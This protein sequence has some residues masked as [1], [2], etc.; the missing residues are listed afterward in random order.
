MLPEVKIGIISDIHYSDGA[1][2]EAFSVGGSPEEY[3]RFSTAGT[4]WAEAVST[5]N[6]ESVDIVFQL[7]DSVD[8]GCTAAQ[9]RTQIQAMVTESG[10]LTMDFAGVTGNH[11]DGAWSDAGGDV[12][13]VANYYTDIDVNHVTR[14]NVYTDGDGWKSY[15]Y[16]LNGIRFLCVLSNPAGMPSGHSDW[17]SARI[18]ETTMPIIVVTHVPVW[19]PSHAVYSS[20]WTFDA[21]YAT[22]EPIL[23][24][25]NVQ[26]VFA[27]HYHW[28]HYD[29]K[30]EDVPCFNFGGSVLCPSAGDNT[31]YIVKIKADAF[32]KGDQNR[33]AI[34]VVGYGNRGTSK[35]SYPIFNIK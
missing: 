26:A 20:G 5:F 7:G 1:D 21:N 27:G 10:N 28:G 34:E 6:S 12:P 13:S 31:Y 9:R 24:S 2:N 33:A 17:L 22:I 4:R 30:K 3:R 14:A 18:V 15:S 8:S 11:E 25:G 32:Y 29:H 16:D 23:K 35:V 19:Y